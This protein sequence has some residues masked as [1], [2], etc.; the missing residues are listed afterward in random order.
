MEHKAIETQ[1]LR[2][3]TYVVGQGGCLSMAIFFPKRVVMAEEVV[4]PD[5]LDMG[6]TGRGSA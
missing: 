1:S 2:Q 4:R 6:M 3:A 5:L